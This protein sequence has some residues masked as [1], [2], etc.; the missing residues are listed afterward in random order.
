VN[1]DT[2]DIRNMFTFSD[3]FAIQE[4]ADFFADQQADGEGTPK[5]WTGPVPILMRMTEEMR[6]VRFESKMVPKARGCASS[7]TVAPRR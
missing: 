3:R 6:V 1:Q 4:I 2:L 5:P 7:A